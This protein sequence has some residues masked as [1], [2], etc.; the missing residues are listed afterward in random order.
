M[1]VSVVERR[2]ATS[3]LP[4]RTNG[5]FTTLAARALVAHRHLAPRRRRRRRRAARA[6]AIDL[7]SVGL[8][9]PLVISPSPCAVRTFWCA[10][11]TPPASCSTGRPAALRR[12]LRE[13]A[14]PCRRSRAGSRGRPS[15]RGRTRAATRSRPCPGRRGSCPL[16][17]AACR[18]RR[19]RRARTPAAASAFHSAS[20]RVAGTMSSKPSSPV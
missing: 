6:S 1:A 14:P 9:V 15:T 2:H 10:R 12:R 20:A 11:S 16:R 13:R 5:G 19:G 18:A 3:I 7:P 17:G 4:L 8:N